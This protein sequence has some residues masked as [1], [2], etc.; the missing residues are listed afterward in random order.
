[1]APEFHARLSI[2]IQHT[3]S[4]ILELNKCLSPVGVSAHK[5]ATTSVHGGGVREERQC[6]LT[7]KDFFF[8]GRWLIALRGTRSSGVDTDAITA[9]KPDNTYYV[10]Y[11]QLESSSLLLSTTRPQKQ[12]QQ[13]N[14]RGLRGAICE[15]KT[16]YQ[17]IL[18]TGDKWASSSAGLFPVHKS[19]QTADRGVCKKIG[20]LTAPEQT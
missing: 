12:Q 6:T 8:K 9:D 15:R 16:P 18:M 4:I 14:Y 17:Y 1:M 3:S 13:H 7:H 20:L 11:T 5:S 2:P 19:R 10:S